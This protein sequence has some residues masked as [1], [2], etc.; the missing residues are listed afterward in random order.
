MPRLR[1]DGIIQEL[2]QSWNI[3]ETH[4]TRRQP[5]CN[6]LYR[7]SSRTRHRSKHSEVLSARLVSEIWSSGYF[8][9]TEIWSLLWP[10]FAVSCHLLHTAIICLAEDFARNHVCSSYGTAMILPTSY[11]CSGYAN[12]VIVLHQPACLEQRHRRRLER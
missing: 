5:E 1:T 4:P 9:F 8:W 10:P 2:S 11:G 6:A 3:L 7:H 12:L